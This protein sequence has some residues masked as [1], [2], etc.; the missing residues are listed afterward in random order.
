MNG[1]K[2]QTSERINLY[3]SGVEWSYGQKE[4]SAKTVIEHPE[5]FAFSEFNLK[6]RNNLKHLVNSKV[7]YIWLK[8]SFYIPENLKNK[9]LALFISLLNFADE[10]YLN[11]EFIGNYGRFEPNEANAGN[12]THFYPMLKKLLNQDCKNEILIKVF[13]QGSSQIGNKILVGEYQ[14]LE[15]FSQ[16]KNFVLATMYSFFEGSLLVLFLLYGL[17]YITQRKKSEYMIFSLLNFYTAQ[18]VFMFYTPLL[19][20]F[21]NCN[22]NY[23]TLVKYFGSICFYFMFYFMSSFMDRF[24]QIRR[25]RKVIGIRLSIIAVQVIVTLIMPDINSLNESVVWLLLLSLIQSV[26]T[27]RDFVFYLFTKKNSRHKSAQLLLFGMIPFFL[28]IFVDI[29]LIDDFSLPYFSFYG[30]MATLCAYLIVLAFKVGKVVYE[31]E[32]FN[33]TLKGEIEIQVQE[34]KLVNQRLELEIKRNKSDLRIASLVQKKTFE[35]PISNFIGWDV[36][37]V[38]EPLSSVSGDMYDFYN[39]GKVLNGFSLFDVSGHGVAASLITMLSK[40]IIKR[41]FLNGVR[42]SLQMSEIMTSINNEIE[43]AKGEAENYM[44]GLLF[45]IDAMDSNGNCELEFTNAG[46]PH[47]V[48]YEA[49][50]N[51]AKYLLTD[52]SVNQYGAIGIKGM[53]VSFQNAKFTISDNDILVCFTDGL[54]EATNSKGIQFGKDNVRHIIEE[55]HEKNAREIANAIFENLKT[56][57]GHE[58]REDDVTILVLKKESPED[59]LE[60][61]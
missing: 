60:E 3:N 7:C 58:Y 59:F 32:N 13:C 11:G 19:P 36:A 23:V 56:Y 50:E 45:Q 51:A 53:P 46:H 25:T 4:D 43:L 10:V 49:K 33:E 5:N 34:L 40:N 16:I 55:N 48:L 2:N 24:M 14:D 29:L 28:G 37:V 31:N 39:A 44:T 61:I 17:L 6:G 54:I 22:F 27:A 12:I 21:Q 38:Y 52:N 30:W 57:I 1:C 35:K 41:T 26:P 42:H 18:F 15:N 8:T 9:D 20:W 47:P